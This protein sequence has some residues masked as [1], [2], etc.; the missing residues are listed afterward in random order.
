[1]AFNF[2]IESTFFK[3]YLGS[4]LDCK[5]VNICIVR[6]VEGIVWGSDLCDQSQRGEKKWPRG[7]PSSRAE[8]AKRWLLI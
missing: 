7:V 8:K 6:V 4:A 2:G 3:I 5:F 1:M